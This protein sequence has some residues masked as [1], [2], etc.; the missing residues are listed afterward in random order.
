[1]PYRSDMFLIR[2]FVAAFV[3]LFA[4]MA[5]PSA[6]AATTDDLFTGTLTIEQGKAILARCDAAG[7]RYVLI[8]GRTDQARAL[9]RYAAPAGEVFDVIGTADDAGGFTTLTV[10]EITMRTPRPICHLVDIDAMFAPAQAQP[11]DQHEKFDLVALIECRSDS[12]TAVRFRN[13]L[14]LKPEVLATAGL[15]RVSSRNFTAEFRMDASLKIFGHATTTLALHPDGF[16]A[17]FGDVSPQALAESLGAKPMLSTNPFIAQKVI[18]TAN[19]QGAVP[20]EIAL[21][22]L[23]VTSRNGLLGKAIAGCLYLSTKNAGR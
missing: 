15:K 13:W 8:D 5:T 14:D 7:N 6:I 3:A 21:R 10:H 1:M 4:I 23:T 12:D 11:V 16:L 2:S 19:A 18:E 9:T 20:G 22:V 17:V